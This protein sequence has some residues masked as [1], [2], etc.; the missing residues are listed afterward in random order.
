MGLRRKIN[1]MV[2]KLWTKEQLLPELI[3]TKSK[4]IHP[5]HGLLI[6]FYLIFMCSWRKK[7]LPEEIFDFIVREMYDEGHLKS[8]VDRN[9]YKTTYEIEVAKLVGDNEVVYH[10]YKQNL[11][12]FKKVLL[13]QLCLLTC[14]QKEITLYK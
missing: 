14:E 7:H 8:S 13:I 2:Q 4:I 11:V 10:L 9:G 6:T 3:I 12:V 5:I 1:L